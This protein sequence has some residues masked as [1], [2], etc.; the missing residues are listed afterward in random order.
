MTKVSTAIKYL[1]WAIIALAALFVLATV[2][3][4]KAFHGGA[5]TILSGS[6][7][8]ALNVGDLVVAKGYNQSN[9]HPGDIATFMPFANDP[10]LVTHRVIAVDAEKGIL[11]KGDSVTAAHD[12]WGYLP[13]AAILGVK[14][15]TIPKAGYVQ[16]WAKNH[17]AFTIVTVAL[18]FGG[19]ELLVGLISKRRVNPAASLAPVAVAGGMPGSVS[20]GVSSAMPSAVAS[21]EN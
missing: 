15:F 19:G 11:T 18:L 7:A 5:Y 6:M 13:P 17:M 4:P 14:W 20:S 21:Y 8:P 2:I 1:Q 16:E 9:L 3:L 12:Q 10:T